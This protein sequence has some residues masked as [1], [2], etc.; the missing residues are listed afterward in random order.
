[1]SHILLEILAEEALKGN[2]PSSTFKAE[3]FVKVASEISQKFNVQCEPKHVDNHFKTV[4]KRM[5]NNNQT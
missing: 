4:K 5:G 3:S 1:M 2:K